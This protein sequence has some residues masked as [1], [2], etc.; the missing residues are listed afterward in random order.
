MPG[1]TAAMRA[2]K[3]LATSALPP[4]GAMGA[5]DWIAV[6]IT[7]SIVRCRNILGSP[8]SQSI[9]TTQ[10]SIA[11]AIAPESVATSPPG[12]YHSVPPCPS[13]R[14]RSAW[15]ET[16]STGNAT[17]TANM[18]PA[19]RPPRTATVAAPIAADPT[20]QNVPRLRATRNRGREEK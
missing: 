16:R 12:G 10:Q 2:A 20:P 7:V 13:G 9:I 17:A 8:S 15:W 1:S 11:P 14:L 19:G 3:V 4:L 18:P 6:P 5:P